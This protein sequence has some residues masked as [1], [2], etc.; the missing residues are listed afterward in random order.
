MAYDIPTD[1]ASNC[2]DVSAE[3]SDSCNYRRRRSGL[4]CRSCETSHLIVLDMLLSKLGG[5]E[6]LHE[7]R[8]EH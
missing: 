4:K 6:V 5:M 1:W 8:S 3:E 7:L 2:P